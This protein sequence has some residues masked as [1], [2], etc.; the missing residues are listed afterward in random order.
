MIRILGRYIFYPY[1]QLFLR[2]YRDVQKGAGGGADES[3]NVG[4]HAHHQEDQEQDGGKGHLN[5]PTKLQET[6]Y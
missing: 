6:R 3:V 1:T 4:P 5:H 2:V